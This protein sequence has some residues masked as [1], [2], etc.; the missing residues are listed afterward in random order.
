MDNDSPPVCPLAAAATP[1]RLLVI[2]YG[3]TLRRDDGAGIGLA[4]L[5][6]KQWHAHGL[7][8]RFIVVPQLTPEL[9]IDI[10]DPEITAVIFVDAAQ[11]APESQIQVSRVAAHGATPTL[12]HQLD[13]CLLLVYAALFYP[14]RAPAWLVTIPGTDFDHGEGFSPAVQQLLAHAPAVAN[15]LLEQMKESRPCM[16]L[17]LPKV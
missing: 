10:S 6:V 1:L 2:A 3:N 13:P 11:T 17:P 9:S 5:L 12:G 14:H 7:C 15:E 16:N 4:G 8:V